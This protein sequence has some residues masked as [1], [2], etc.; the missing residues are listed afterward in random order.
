MSIKSLAHLAHQSAVAAAGPAFKRSHFY[1][2]MAAAFG[3]GSYAALGAESVLLERKPL[4]AESTAGRLANVRSR[5]ISLG[6]GDPVSE[7]VASITCGVLAEQDVDVIRLNDLV[8]RLRESGDE[9]VSYLDQFLQ[10]DEVRSSILLESLQSAAERGSALAHYA[11]ALLHA[12]DLPDDEDDG[13]ASACW[14]RQRRAGVELSGAKAEWADEYDRREESKSRYEHHLRAAAS[15]GYKHALVDVA[16]RFGDPSVFESRLDLSDEDPIRMAELARSLGRPDQE[17]HWLTI[18]AEGG[19]IEAMRDLI[20]GYDAGDLEA[21]W[22]WLH[23]AV[24]HGEDLTAD[25]YR[26]IHEDGSPYDDDVGG[27]MY[28]D[29]RDGVKLERLAPDADWRSQVAALE[30]FERV[31][32]RSPV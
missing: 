32:D 8:E 12:H 10:A 21:C 20:E 11:I 14:S 24:L 26:A 7:V 4:I 31:R 15:L 25:Q 13:T 23:L 17:K 2:L 27:A 16:E 29:G 6:Y 28:A 9:C 30:I 3:Y 22:K 18:A 5:C 19:D 1:E